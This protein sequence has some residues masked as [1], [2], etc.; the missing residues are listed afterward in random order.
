[1]IQKIV[2]PGFLILIFLPLLLMLIY[3]ILNRLKLHTADVRQK[4]FLIINPYKNTFFFW[5]YII[6]LKKISLIFS[7]IF[8]NN[9]PLISCLSLLAIIFVSSLMQVL[10]QPFKLREFNNLEQVQNMTIYFTFSA[11][12]FFTYKQTN[13]MRLIILLFL[14]FANIFFFVYWL[15]IYIKIFIKLHDRCFRT[16]KN[17][18]LFR[19]LFV[20]VRIIDVNTVQNLQKKRLNFKEKP[21]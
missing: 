8:L 11:A 3:L 20:K 15:K 9:S 21:K 4:A 1:M 19:S 2:L 12:L 13:T 18:K 6:L 10:F 7:T 16:I 17:S 14:V 5:E